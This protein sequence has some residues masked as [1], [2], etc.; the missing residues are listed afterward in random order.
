MQR[1]LKSWLK[2]F[3]ALNYSLDGIRYAMKHE[4]A[5]QQEVL[6]GLPMVIYA[7]F[8][9][10]TPIEKILLIGSVLLVWMAELLNTAIE[11]I[12]S[13]ISDDVHPMSKVAKDT[14]SAAVFFALLLTGVTWGLILLG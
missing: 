1:F 5:F 2:I 8:A 7:A 11:A 9:A 14:G 6:L 4:R 12:I 10:H 3:A 13:R